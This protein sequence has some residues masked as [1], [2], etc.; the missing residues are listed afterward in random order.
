MEALEYLGSTKE[1]KNIKRKRASTAVVSMIV[2]PIFFVLS[3]ICTI[4][5]GAFIVLIIFS[6]GLIAALKY[7]YNVLFVDK[8]V[9]VTYA[10]IIDMERTKRIVSTTRGKRGRHKESNGILSIRVGKEKY[11][12][13]YYY[14]YE[15]LAKFDDGQYW[16]KSDTSNYKTEYFKETV[17]QQM[18]DIEVINTTEK[19]INSSEELYDFITNHTRHYVGEKVIL[20]T[21]D[22]AEYYIVSY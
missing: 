7:T 8:P 11:K 20:F 10:E 14:E 9:M 12:N 17:A 2:M 5:A 4:K 15:F 18:N 3:I 19:D 21:F 13:K 16:A 22:N 6:I 1:Y